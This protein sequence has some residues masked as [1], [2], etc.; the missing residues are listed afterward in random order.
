MRISTRRGKKAA[1]PLG[2]W[3][4]FSRRPG[5]CDIAR[6]P[7]SSGCRPTAT[8]WTVWIQPN[9]A[10]RKVSSGCLDL[11]CVHSKSKSAVVC[12]K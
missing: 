7:S 6:M 2:T 1:E 4:G 8:L 12:H 10:S 9:L 3:R 11:L 5:D